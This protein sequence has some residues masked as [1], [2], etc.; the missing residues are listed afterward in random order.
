MI[1]TAPKYNE[2]IEKAILGLFI[3][4]NSVFIANKS[5]LNELDF[6]LTANQIV[7]GAC[8]RLVADGYRC[9]LLSLNRYL[10]NIKQLEVI[11]GRSYLVDLVSN[12]DGSVVNLESHIKILKELSKLRQ[13]SVLANSL[14]EAISKENFEAIKKI[15]EELLNLEAD[16][17][18]KQPLKATDFLS[19]TK[20]RFE[21]PV[22]GIQTPFPALNDLISGFGDGELFTLSGNSG[23]GKSLLCLQFALESSKQNKKVLYWNLEMSPAQFMPRLIIQHLGVSSYQWKYKNF[24]WHEAIEEKSDLI[25]DLP[26]KLM[27]DFATTETIYS[28][29]YLEKIKHG[30]DFLIIDYFSLLSDRF[31]G[32]EIERDK[33]LIIRLKEIAKRLNI[34]VFTPLAMSK[35]AIRSGDTPKTEDQLGSIM[36]VYTADTMMSL[37]RVKGENVGK[38]WITKNRTGETGVVD[39]TF[40]SDYLKFYE[41]A[42]QINTENIPDY[43]NDL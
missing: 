29:A 24:N 31:N 3:R 8:S 39:L 33:Y 23:A 15:K 28:T 12:F 35:Q 4:D 27:F 42:K 37:S 7:F 41:T 22:A 16:Y 2:A 25:N 34:P 20:K 43:Y 26:I 17:V 38:I 6:Y 14:A 9:D 13:E 30:L 32:S 18:V 40:D 5:I 21:N 10:E 19:E 11:G 1:N 36:Q